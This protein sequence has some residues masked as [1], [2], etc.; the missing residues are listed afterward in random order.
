MSS[1]EDNDSEFTDEET[2]EEEVEV[3]GDLVLFNADECE[4]L[5]YHNYV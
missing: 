1:C 4:Y 5:M 2:K 3:K